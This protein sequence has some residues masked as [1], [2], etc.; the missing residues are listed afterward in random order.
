[1][2]RFHLLIL[3]LKAGT[4]FTFPLTGTEVVEEGST[5]SKPVIKTSQLKKDDQVHVHFGSELCAQ[6][7]CH[8]GTCVNHP[9]TEGHFQ[10]QGGSLV[11]VIPKIN[12][13]DSGLYRVFHNGYQT[14]LNFTLDVKG[15]TSAMPDS[16]NAAQEMPN[17]ST[18]RYTAVAV[19]T[20]VLVVI[21]IGFICWKKFRSRTERPSGQGEC[22][23][24]SDTEQNGL[25]RSTSPESTHEPEVSYNH[26]NVTFLL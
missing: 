4:C 1:M 6:Y 8:D 13:T 5:F 23:E 16:T 14:V 17:N 20:V 3:L 22:R 21:V 15:Q 19:P 2:M 12:I 26:Q 7:F 25:L 11:L 24:D 18:W 9:T 10:V